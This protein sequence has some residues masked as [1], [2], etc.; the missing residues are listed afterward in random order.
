[1][2]GGYVTGPVVITHSG[3]LVIAARQQVVPAEAGGGVAVNDEASLAGSN[4]AWR[5]LTPSP[6]LEQPD[7]GEA[8]AAEEG[9]PGALPVRDG[10]HRADE[11]PALHHAPAR[12]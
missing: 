9:E 6:S 1:M 4:S 3:S 10:G 8:E 7:S 5:P 11:E 2:I 12:A